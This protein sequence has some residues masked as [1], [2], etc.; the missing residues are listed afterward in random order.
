MRSSWPH[1]RVVAVI[2]SHDAMSSSSLERASRSVWLRESHASRRDSHA[3]RGASQKLRSAPLLPLSLGE[4]EDLPPLGGESNALRR[5]GVSA[6]NRGAHG[7]RGND[8]RLK[9]DAARRFPLP[10]A[11]GQGEG[12]QTWPTKTAA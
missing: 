3:A 9:K 12:N 10:E 11:E 5:A 7:A 8:V 6:S 2:S 1:V 4:R